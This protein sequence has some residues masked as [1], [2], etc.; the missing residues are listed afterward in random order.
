MRR[1]AALLIAVACKLVPTHLRA[2][3]EAEW[4][5]ECQT[6]ALSHGVRSSL[7]Y[8][9]RLVLGAPRTGFVLRTNNR[10]VLFDVLLL[11]IKLMVPTVF[12]MVHAVVTRQSLVALAYSGLCIGLLVVASSAW[13]AESGLFG[14]KISASGL[15]IV[16]VCSAAITFMNLLADTHNPAL[17]GPIR[18]LPGSVGVQIGLLVVMLSAWLGAQRVEVARLGLSLMTLGLVI[19]ATIGVLNTVLVETWG[20]RIFHA[21]SVPSALAVASG[22]WL[23]RREGPAL[24]APKPSQEVVLVS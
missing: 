1:L 18:V 13:S 24:I 20:E 12:F 10:P 7:R 15:I 6:I 21:V 8:A 3:Y 19:W 17:D 5:A 16:L 2:Q 22:C 23:I 14:G 11:S 4:S 9:G